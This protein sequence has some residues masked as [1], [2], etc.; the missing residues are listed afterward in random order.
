M[1]WQLYTCPTANLEFGHKE[2]LLRLKTRQTFDQ[3]DVWTKSSI[4][5]F[6][7]GTPG[8]T[9]TDE[10][11]ENFQTASP[12]L[13]SENYVALFSGGAKICNKIFR[14]GVTPPLFRKFAT[15]FFGVEWTPPPFSRKFIVFPLKI[16]K[17]CSFIILKS[18]T[19]FFG[20]EMTPPSPPIGN[21]PKI[22]PKWST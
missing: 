5:E 21:F 3:S 19:K 11:S 1:T 18:A 22:H 2:W 16:T 10:F 8:P 6:C 20:S 12:P 17:K 15:K 14:I 7:L 4:L 13:V 9:K